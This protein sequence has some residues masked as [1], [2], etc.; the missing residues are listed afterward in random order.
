MIVSTQFKCDMC[1][2]IAQGQ[3]VD[4]PKGWKWLILKG[5]HCPKCARIAYNKVKNMTK[6]QLQREYDVFPMRRLRE[7]KN[8]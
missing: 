4:L 2:V 6:K 1:G 5:D 8:G 7:L 3:G